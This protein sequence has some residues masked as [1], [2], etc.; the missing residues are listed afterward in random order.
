MPEETQG[1]INAREVLDLAETGEYQEL[2]GERIRCPD[3]KGGILARFYTGRDDDGTLRGWVWLP[4]RVAGGGEK[5]A[6]AAMP[7]TAPKGELIF[8]DFTQCSR[9]RGTWLV[10]PCGSH[11]DHVEVVGKFIVLTVGRSHTEP[12][13][14]GDKILSGTITG[15]RITGPVTFEAFRF[16]ETTWGTI[17]P[18]DP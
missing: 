3:C 16:S 12:G 9:C 10:F 11:L 17:V 15:D 14:V 4:A 2:K 1:E 5:V 18:G 13:R 6:P 7:I 8:N